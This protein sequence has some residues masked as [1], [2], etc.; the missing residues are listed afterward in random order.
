LL[1]ALVVFETAFSAF[2][3]ET[4]LRIES[5]EL[6]L[7]SNSAVTDPVPLEDQNRYLEQVV[8]VTPTPIGPS[9]L[10]F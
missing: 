5:M 10:R 7:I 8:G 2:S 6:L 4:L 9:V 1:R 3:A